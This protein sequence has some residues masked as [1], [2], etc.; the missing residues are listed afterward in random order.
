MPINSRPGV[1][2]SNCERFA[3]TLGNE[4]HLGS[5]RLFDRDNPQIRAGEI[6]GLISLAAARRQTA[7]M[8]KETAGMPVLDIVTP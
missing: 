5:I 7:E 4:T 3:I 8:T 6:N 1:L 2:P